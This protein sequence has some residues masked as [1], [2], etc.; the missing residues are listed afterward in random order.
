MFASLVER[1]SVERL[2]AGC[3]DGDLHRVT[4]ES[5]NSS[6]AATDLPLIVVIFKPATTHEERRVASRL[7]FIYHPSWLNRA[8][9][10][11]LKADTPE[12]GAGG[13]SLKFVDR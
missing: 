10:K 8:A 12:V 11:V 2:S 4:K 9:G 7:G 3:G 1:A 5:L 13:G 6:L